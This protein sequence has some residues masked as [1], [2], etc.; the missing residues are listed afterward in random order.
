VVSATPSF[1]RSRLYRFDRYL[2]ALLE[3]RKPS[4]VDQITAIPQVETDLDVAHRQHHARVRARLA[5]DYG[6]GEQLH[7]VAIS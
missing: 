3:S 7:V 2:P 6:D 5:P 1:S 4:E